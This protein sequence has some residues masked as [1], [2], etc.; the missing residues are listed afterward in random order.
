LE[1]DSPIPAQVAVPPDVTII[2]T[3]RNEERNLPGCLEAIEAQTVA[4]D[5]LE[6]LV[7][8]NNSDDRTVELATGRADKVL[9][10]GPERSAQRNFGV[11]Q[12]SAPY[13]LY[14]DADMRLS[15]TVV[16][17]CL[18]A[19]AEDAT[20][21]GVYIPEHVVGSGF[22]I[23]VRNFERSFYD[24]TCIDAVRFITRAV[25]LELG[26]FDLNLCG[27]EDWDFD[28]RLA[29]RGRL[30]LL[31]AH[32]DHDEGAFDLRR[33]LRKKSYYAQSFDAYATKWNNDAV[34]RKQLGFAYRFFGVFL[35]HGKWRRLLAHPLLTGGMY[36]LRF[37]VGCTFLR[38]KLTGGTSANHY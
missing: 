11:E 4:R 5:R 23:K 28:R 14:L 34:V 30:H 26:G 37:L 24:A 19:V 29:A 38:R 7:V 2:I 6:V 22:W 36:F 13:V 27:P 16:A 17:E 12:A 15:P 21:V 10:K 33:Y 25:F 1:D 3:T 35:E 20:I 31:T 9:A 32:L 18:A 8:D